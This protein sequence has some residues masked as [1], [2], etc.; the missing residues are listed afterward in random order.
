MHVIGGVNE[1][2]KS[3]KQEYIYLMSPK[4][5]VEMRPRMRESISL[6]RMK[7]M[8][9]AYDVATIQNRKNNL[10]SNLEY[11]IKNIIHCGFSANVQ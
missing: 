4:I 7:K 6:L 10:V 8:E 2:S 3:A 9:D 5:G 11:F 1:K